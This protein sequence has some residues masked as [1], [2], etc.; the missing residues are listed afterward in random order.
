MNVITICNADDLHE[1]INHPVF[2]SGVVDE[3]IGENMWCISLDENCLQQ[4]TDTAIIRFFDRLVIEKTHQIRL[5]HPQM[6]AILYVW[7][8]R[9][10][11]QLRLN[12]LSGAST[13]L[14]FQCRI[15]K[16]SSLTSIVD[17]FL[18]TVRSIAY[19]GEQEEFI[20]PTAAD[21]DDDDEQDFIL[22]VYAVMLNQNES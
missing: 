14:P 21:F 22:D 1:I 12:I 13:D 20:E 10:A 5:L 15:Q 18:N 4:V 7:F 16:L 2:L 3:E 8:D 11:L 6:R 9:Q 19:H 17:N